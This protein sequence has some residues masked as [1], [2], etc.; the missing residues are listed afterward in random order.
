MLHP[1]CTTFIT[2]NFRF[3]YL[4]LGYGSKIEQIFIFSFLKIVRLFRQD[5]AKVGSHNVPRPWK[6]PRAGLG[7]IKS[8]EPAI[9]VPA[10]SYLVLLY[11]GGG[12]VL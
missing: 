4:L 3:F 8:S 6:P 9:P 12:N 10:R 7:D 11:S 2:G 5:I 1:P